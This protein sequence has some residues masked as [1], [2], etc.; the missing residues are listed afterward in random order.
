VTP[1]PHAAS[2]AHHFED[3]AQQRASSTL[4]VWIF[5]LTE[6]L[7][8]GAIFGGYA[9]YRMKFPEAFREG[10]LH[11]DLA[12]GTVNTTILIASSFV[13]ALAVH[14]ARHGFT[15]RLV[16]LLGLAAA[17]GAGFL[18]IK[19]FEY[20]AKLHDGLLPGPGFTWTGRDSNHVEMFFV[21][22]FV[23]TALH[24][25]HVT[26]GVGC[27]AWASARAR[28]GVFSGAASMQVEGIGL[29]WHFVD[30][31]WIFLFPLLYL[32]DRVP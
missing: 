11:L 20:A 8:F 1:A 24:A 28:T 23:T 22:Y 13:V 2:H 12:L 18:V 32:V 6:V 30:I 15:R 29:Y 14:A 31:V 4:G 3:A 16:V 10:S 17:M 21:V 19:G 27:L 7:F 25:L 26:V 9:A 5:L